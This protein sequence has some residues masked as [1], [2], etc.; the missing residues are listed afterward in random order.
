MELVKQSE[1]M[2]SG[3]KAQSDEPLPSAQQ[4]KHLPVG[5][6]EVNGNAAYVAPPKDTVGV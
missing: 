6:T 4:Y 5:K 1:V 2:M 3:R